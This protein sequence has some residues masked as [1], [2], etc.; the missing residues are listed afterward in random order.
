[1]SRCR[2]AYVNSLA[3]ISASS[4]K[5]S[6]LKPWPRQRPRGTSL[7]QGPIL[8]PKFGDST[9]G[10]HLVQNHAR[11]PLGFDPVTTLSVTRSD[12]TTTSIYI[13]SHW[14]GNRR[15]INPLLP[16]RDSHP[17][18]AMPTVL[19]VVLSFVGLYLVHLLLGLRRASRN[20]GSV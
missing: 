1:M 7:S 12:R 9:V 5:T 3:Y 16:H 18:L 17:P 11:R 19:S 20:V 14:L 10:H 13:I 8:A 6:Q 2:D 15:C 4:K